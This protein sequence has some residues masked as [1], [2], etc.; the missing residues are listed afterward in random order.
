MSETIELSILLFSLA[1]IAGIGFFALM[2]IGLFFD[3]SRKLIFQILTPMRALVAGLVLSLI[4]IGGSLY[5]SEIVGF[6]VCKLCWAQRIFLYPHAI[7]FG[8]GLFRRDYL[9]WWYSLPM[10]LIGGAFALYH[11]LVQATAGGVSC[12]A[13]GACAKVYFDAVE[14]I[15][16]PVMGLAAFLLLGLFSGLAYFGSRA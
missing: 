14:T 13:G 12:G 6:S 1:T 4:V 16:F 15:T 7:L 5:Y 2:I 11:I 8:V 3:T 9:I 10:V